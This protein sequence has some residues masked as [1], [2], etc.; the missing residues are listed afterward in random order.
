MVVQRLD[1][2]EAGMAHRILG[3]LR[4]AHEQE[5]RTIG[6]EPESGQS[7]AKIL[8]SADFHLGALEQDELVGV[9][10]VG[11]ED[12]GGEQLELKWLAVASAYQRRGIA[13]ALLRQVL[14]SGGVAFAV[15]VA[16]VNAPALALYRG[17]GFVA[18]RLGVLGA[19]RIPVVRLRRAAV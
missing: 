14:S 8:Q 11:V 1:N 9:L 16:Q 7:L 5:S 12:G 4:S 19:H 18:L 3:L 6:V 13:T 10:V 15:T 17:M 2:R